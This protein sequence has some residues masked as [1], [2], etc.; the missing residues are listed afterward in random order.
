MK[1]LIPLLLILTIAGGG[2]Y[3]YLTQGP[4][5]AAPAGDG[6]IVGSGTIEAEAISIATQA[7]GRVAAVYVEE[8]DTVEPGAVLLELDDSLLLAQRVELEAAIATARAN[9]AAVRDRPRPEDITVAEAELAQ[10]RAQ[11]DS[12]YHV[13]Q[14][15]LRLVEDPQ[16]LAVPI[17]ELE[18]QIKQAEGMVDLAQA[19]SKAAGIQEE[20]ASRNQR[21]H[22]AMVGYQIAQKQRQ[23]ADI[24][25]D[26]AEAQLAALR[27]QLAHLWEQYNN[28][29]ALQV[30]A[31]QA[32][33]AYRIAQAAVELARARLTAARA[34]P[35]A[36]EVAVAEAQVAQAA[37]A[38]TLLDVQ[39]EQLILTAPREGLITS[40]IADPGELA[41][42]GATLLE[43]ADLDRVTLRVFIPETQIGRVKLGQTARVTI[44]SVDRPFEGEVTFIAHEAEFTPRNV[45]TREERVNLVFAV[46]ISLENP[47]HILKPGMPA[48]AEILP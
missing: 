29:I 44:D 24:G 25:V 28:P 6:P 35:T 47:E 30:Q 19:A 2:A 34:A 3:W 10:A 31:H 9:L 40:R 21:D 43:L 18:A 37:S 16:D 11:R 48:D 4:A 12:A 32:E 20:A 26:L 33:A 15:M 38:L 39:V 13:W 22:A 36:E 17:R 14:Q 46:E 45:Q 5:S 8:G 7:G 42:P 23:A 27:V 1:R 41:A